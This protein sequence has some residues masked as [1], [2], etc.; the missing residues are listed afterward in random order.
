[1][2]TKK[3]ILSVGLAASLAAIAVVGSSLA[4]FTDK[5]YK[6]NTFTIGNVGIVLTEP[7]WDTEGAAEAI[8]MYPGEA[9][10]KDPTVTNDG[11]NPAF[12]RVKVTG[13][14]ENNLRYRTD[15]QLDKLGDNWEYNAA[16]GY[17][18]YTKV[19]QP[20]ESTDALFDQIYLWEGVE[21]DMTGAERHVEVTAE[22][23]QAQGAAAQW[24]RVEAMDMEEIAAWFNTHVQIPYGA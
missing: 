22:A 8:D 7:K 14:T 16:D 20:G 1:M 24:S 11:K 17:F 4:Y 9:V 19:L 5:D 13:L 10:A 2:N 15:Y 6:D 23:I 18:Y 21:N 3:K 12:V